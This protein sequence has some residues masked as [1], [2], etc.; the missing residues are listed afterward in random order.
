M[1]KIITAS[2]VAM[3]AVTAAHA[4]IASTDYVTTRTGT[5]SF[6]SGAA[7]G[8]TDLTE[9][10][11]AVD[12]ALGTTTGNAATKSELQIAQETL[13]ADIDKKVATETYNTFVQTQA[14]KDSGQ[15]SK[16]TALEASLGENGDTAKAIA[17]AQLTADGA[18]AVNTQQGTAITNLQNTVNALDDTYATD[19]QAAAAAK[20]ATD[21]LNLTAVGAEGSFISTVSQTDG[22]VAAGTTPFVEA[23]N[24]DSKTSTIAPQTKAVAAYVDAQLNV[25]NQANTEIAGKVGALEAAVTAEGALLDQFSDYK[26]ANDAALEKEVQDRT[27]AD[28]ALGGRVD[29]LEDFNDGLET[30]ETVNATANNVVTSVTTTNGKV[31]AVGSAQITNAMVADTAGIEKG[32]LHSDVQKSLALAD[33]AMQ[34]STLKLLASWTEEDCAT[35]NVTCSLV[36]KGGDIAW[37]AVKY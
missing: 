16:I 4:D 3:M 24:D 25:V 37:E 26:T 23:I 30:A 20:A 11:K 8:K 33:S 22:T 17:T 28:T 1:K 6:D 35:T 36:S 14:T 12:A 34:V 32:K 9:A 5:V 29:A 13:Q 27:A 31:T 15:D 21:A 18:V 2:L 7:K 10:I 19:E